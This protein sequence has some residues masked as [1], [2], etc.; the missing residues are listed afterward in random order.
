MYPEPRVPH[1]HPHFHAR[2]GG[3]S[4]VYRISPASRIT[5]TIPAPQEALVLAWAGAHE[6]ELKENWARLH[7]GQSALPIPP[8]A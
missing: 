3:S 6:Q 7:R 5:G 4:A 8:L 2:Y 1:H